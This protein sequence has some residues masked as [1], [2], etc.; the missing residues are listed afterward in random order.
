MIHEATQLAGLGSGVNAGRCEISLDIHGLA[1]CDSPI[2]L[3]VMLKVVHVTTRV[4]IGCILR[5]SLVRCRHGDQI[6]DVFN[7]KIAARERS[8]G[9]YASSFVLECSNL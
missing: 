1:T 5:F 4:V 6:A 7:H 2:L 9:D 8:R 3:L